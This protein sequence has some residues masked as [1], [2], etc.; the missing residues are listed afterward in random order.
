MRGHITVTGVFRP[1]LH[2]TNLV[3]IVRA[4]C[5]YPHTPLSH[6]FTFVLFF[7]L[8]F[9]Y[10]P[11]LLSPPSCSPVEFLLMPYPFLL[12]SYFSLCF[13]YHNCMPVPIFPGKVGAG[14]PSYLSFLVSLL[15]YRLFFLLVCFLLF[16]WAFLGCWIVVCL[17]PL[18]LL[19]FFFFSSHDIALHLISVSCFRSLPTV[20]VSRS[21]ASLCL[22]SPAF[23]VVSLILYFSASH[24]PSIILFRCCCFLLCCSSL[25]P[26]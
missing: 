6:P 21:S 15:M 11:F 18:L 26:V 24:P 14:L 7:P 5:T 25:S 3:S 23:A 10:H 1:N 17:L 2:R 16:F 12:H 8:V 9:S 13:C 19:L 20:D 4:S 22:A